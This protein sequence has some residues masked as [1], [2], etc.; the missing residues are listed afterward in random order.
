MDRMRILFLMGVYPSYGGVEKVTT[1]LTNEL[2]CRGWEVSIVSFEQPYPELASQELDSRVKLYKLEYPV[3]SLKNIKL[4]RRILQ[5]RGIDIIISQWAVPFHVACL[6]YLAKCGLSCKFVTVH[7]NN[8]NTNGRIKAVELDIEGGNGIKII[9]RL[10]LWAIRSISR[11]SLRWVYKL[12]DLYVVLSDSFKGIAKEY[13]MLNRMDHIL[14]IP[15][16]LTI[17][18]PI[19]I[20]EK[21]DEII[22]VG[23][24]EYNQKRTFRVLEIWKKLQDKFP[25]WNITIIG[26][27]P[28]RADLEK[29][30][31]QYGV[32]RVAITG[33]TDPTIYYARAKILVMVSEYEGF[34]LVIVEGM[35][36]GVVPAV[37]AAF[38]VVQD[39]IPEDKLCGLVI[40]YPY[41][42]DKFAEALS[43]LMESPESLSVMKDNAIRQSHKYSLN[44]I[45]DQWEIVLKS[46]MT[47]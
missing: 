19:D 40:Q 32:N 10:K 14:V 20:N 27:G 31:I 5:E 26:D 15:N 13:M 43:M 35:S 46:L 36:C 4:L 38:P 34:G 11:I 39:I 45:V 9:N 24:I 22:W 23:R 29:R 8:P 7:H 2:V 33:F 1:I 6:C 3:C 25:D 37:L 18:P 17:N 30:I 12:S 44:S 42:C 41:D 47:S 28:D 16:P 21:T